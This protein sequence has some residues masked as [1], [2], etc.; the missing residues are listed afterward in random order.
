MK[1]KDRMSAVRFDDWSVLSGDHQK[2]EILRNHFASSYPSEEEV[3][4][5]D[6]RAATWPELQADITVLND[7]DS[8]SENLLR[9]LRKL[10]R[11]LMRFFL[12]E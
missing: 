3:K 1:V 7:V 12:I 11:I 6:V 8:P 9:H 5:S 4:R 2:V 10:K